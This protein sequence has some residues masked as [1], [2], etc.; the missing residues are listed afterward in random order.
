MKQIKNFIAIFFCL[1]MVFGGYTTV[2]A[3]EANIGVTNDPSYIFEE[4]VVPFSTYLPTDTWDLSKNTKY[5]FSGKANTETLYTNYLFTGVSKVKIHVNNTSSST[6]KVELKK[7]K[8]GLNTVTSSKKIEGNNY[9]EWTVNVDSSS[10]YY[11]RFVAPCN[12]NG[13]IEKA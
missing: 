3:D 1:L 13:Y 5:N 11:I 12:F 10:K 2:Y 7:D 6:L 9:I 4:G 8:S